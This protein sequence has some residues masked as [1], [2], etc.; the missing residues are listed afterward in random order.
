MKALT[1]HY[2]ESPLGTMLAIAD[3]SALY[4]LEFTERTK[5]QPEIEKLKKQLKATIIEGITA[6][7]NS[8][9]NELKLYFAGS[10]K[11]FTTPLVTQGTSFQ[12]QAW[13]ELQKIPYGETRSYAEQ[14]KAIKRPTAFRAVARA[15][16]TNHFVIIIPCH[17]II[18]ANGELG[19]YASGLE[20]KEWLLKHEKKYK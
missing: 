17:R 3:E 18:N 5:L 19:G 14:A 15:N 1:S 12:N 16:S 2:F 8:I 10:L 4:L 9:K 7:I 13:K 6:P 11:K 20:R